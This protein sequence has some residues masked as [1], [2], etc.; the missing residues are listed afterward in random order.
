MISASQDAYVVVDTSNESDPE[1]IRDRNLGGLDFLRTWYAFE[2]LGT[3]R[4][5]SVS[6]VKFDLGGV[7]DR[8]IASA[9]LQMYSTA[10]TLRP[11]ARLVDVHAVSDDSWSEST[12]T[13]NTRPSWDVNPLA[14]TAVYGPSV[15]YS[16]DVTSSVQARARSSGVAS[17]VVGLRAIDDNFEEQVIFAARESGDNGPRLLVTYE[18]TGGIPAM[19]LAAGGAGVL[20]LLIAAYF[21]GRVVARRGR[22][23]APSRTSDPQGTGENSTQ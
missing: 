11:P 19:Y 3:E 15:W 2:V 9:H 8:K 14:S 12:V 17:F 13:Y 10:T 1:G 20:V 5:V 7:K 21:A 4:I 16:W 18:P 6:L 22:R 23:P